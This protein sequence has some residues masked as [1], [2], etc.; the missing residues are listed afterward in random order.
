MYGEPCRVLRCVR[1]GFLYL[2]LERGLVI[3]CSAWHSHCSR[4]WVRIPE[5]TIL[6]ERQTPV[7]RK[8]ITA[9]RACT[10]ALLGLALLPCV[11]GCSFN[12]YYTFANTRKLLESNAPGITKVGFAPV[13]AVQ[14]TIVSPVTIYLD[15][16][17]Y[18]TDKDH[19]Y[20]SYLGMQTVIA[21][22]M[23][24]VY[25]ALASLMILPVDSIWFP[26][27]G[28]VDTIWAINTMEGKESDAPKQSGKSGAPRGRDVRT[29]D[30]PHGRK[31]LGRGW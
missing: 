29:H 5:V 19:V 6:R 16:A 3:F 8:V 14:E 10:F 21:S 23:H 13:I 25:K 9:M 20:L 28:T 27:A 4:G 1:Q 2:A 26:I 7:Q 24:G 22:D 12:D 11:L 18:T 15:T 31:V 30:D 17:N